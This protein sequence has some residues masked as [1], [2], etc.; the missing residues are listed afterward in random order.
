MAAG[1]Y[2]VCES[3]AIEDDP[4]ALCDTRLRSKYTFLQKR[5]AWMGE[6][7]FCVPGDGSHVTNHIWRGEKGWSK[8][9]STTY[10]RRLKKCR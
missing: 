6:S 5:Q 7:L 4:F 3:A 10:P 8:K 1:L 9:Q 2:E